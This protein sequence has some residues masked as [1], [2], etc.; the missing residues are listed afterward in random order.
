MQR[1]L[2]STLLHAPHTVS[3]ARKGAF[4]FHKVLAAQQVALTRAA[5]SIKKFKKKKKRITHFK[6]TYPGVLSWQRSRLD[7]CGE[8]QACLSKK[9]SLKGF[10]NKCYKHHYFW[11][12]PQIDSQSTVLLVFFYHGVKMS[13]NGKICKYGVCLKSGGL[14][15]SAAIVTAI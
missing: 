15:R 3:S 11:S 9:N 13:N 8:G 12:Y 5:F 14:V 7:R 2:R 10:K 4:F 6:N 1:G